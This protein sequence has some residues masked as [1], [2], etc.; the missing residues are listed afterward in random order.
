MPL[1]V[2]QYASAVVRSGLVTADEMKALWAALPAGQ[3]PKDGD[4][5][6]KVLV[7]A[8]KLTEFQ[9]GELASGSDT[10]LALGDYL[11]LARIGAGGMGQVFKAEHRHMR[12]L[13]AI[14]LLPATLT[15]DEAA[16][17]RFQREVQAAARLSHTNIVQTFDAG[18]QRGVWYL[19]MEYVEGRDL[20]AL[21]KANGPLTVHDAVN[22]TLQAARGL[23]FAHGDGVVHRDIKPANLLLDSKG[24]VKIL[25][26]GLARIDEGDSADHQLTNTGQVMGTVD[27]MAPEQATNTHSA[28]ARSDVYSLGCTLFRLLT[29]GNVYEGTTVVEKILAHI[30]HPVPSLCERSP[31]VPEEIDRI[32][33][34]MVAKKPEDRHQTAAE[35]VKDLEAWLRGS[36]G[37]ESSFATEDSK[38]H[39]FIQSVKTPGKS[40]V[41]SSSSTKAGVATATVAAKPTT[42][43]QPDVTISAQSLDVDTDPHSQRFVT[44][45]PVASPKPMG[46]GASKIPMPVI[47]AG[48]AAGFL[49]LMLGI[50]M[51]VRDRGGQE[52][53]RVK[54][55]DGGTATV[56]TTEPTGRGTSLPSLDSIKTPPTPKPSPPSIPTQPAGPKPPSVAKPTTSSGEDVPATARWPLA[57]SKPEDIAWL[58]TIP[59]SVVN[60]R[61]P[62]KAWM[63]SPQGAPPT[64]PATVVGVEFRQ[65]SGPNITDETLKRV[66]TLTDLEWLKLGFAASDSRMTK[67]GLWHLTKLPHLQTLVLYRAGPPDTDPA[68][69]A[70]FP[71]LESL[72]FSF[73][74]TYHWEEGVT[75]SATIREITMYRIPLPADWAPFAR[76]PRLECVR[77]FKSSKEEFR[78]RAQAVQAVAP[79]VRVEVV[80]ANDSQ[81]NDPAWI[82]DFVTEPT[83]PRPGSHSASAPVAT[84]S[85]PVVTAAGT[86]VPPPAV[87]PFDA[88]QAKAHQEAWAKYLGEPVETTNS[89]G[90][91]LTIIPPG[92]FK[93]GQDDSYT[94]TG[95]VPVTLTQPFRLGSHEVTQ[96]QWKAVMGTEPWKF[97]TKIDEGNSYPASRIPWD[98]AI[99]FCQKLTEKERAAGLIQSDRAYRLPTEA[100]WEIACRA[101]TATPR[102]FVVSGADLAEFDDY[103]WVRAPVGTHPHEVGLKK[104]NPWGLYDIY[105]N[106]AEWCQ[107]WGEGPLTGGTDPVGPT[108][109]TKRCVRGNM[110]DSKPLHVTSDFRYSLD[111]IAAHVHRNVGF[112]VALSRT[113]S[114]VSTQARVPAAVRTSTSPAVPNP[115]IVPSPSGRY[116]IEFAGARVTSPAPFVSEVIIDNLNLDDERPVT[117]ELAMTWEEGSDRQSIYLGHPGGT[118]IGTTSRNHPMMKRRSIAID[119]IGFETNKHVHLALVYGDG[120]LRGFRDGKLVKM[121]EVNPADPVPQRKP[122]VLGKGLKGRITMARISS[123]ARYTADYKPTLDF[124]PDQHTIALYRFDKDTGDVLEDL[125]GNNHHGKIIGATWVPVDAPSLS[126]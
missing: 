65:G 109:G 83:A 47:V 13:A 5:L 72:S 125:S 62:K 25:D 69:L 77:F 122:F 99:D 40:G 67:A 78:K 26:M 111:P 45:S 8:G 17:R 66:A 49:F 28:D 87:A 93:V 12:R 32:F 115:P 21:V 94:R 38:L 107:D 96:G 121:V 117:L 95:S 37:D 91:K 98:A 15:K 74:P 27:Y 102:F 88:A 85:K 39:D 19:V 116:A 56:E 61:S 123:V 43:A 68:V 18:V 97:D 36:G 84:P 11:L 73:S 30:G 70:A 114:G 51:I 50:W 106:V 29:A 16:V 124:T 120:K 20:S 54:I 103:A 48:G 101:G 63:L 41:L 10:P 112:R 100:E 14:K 35:V 75:R 6:A 4:G 33:Q 23:A 76:M 118:C 126:P 86:H 82:R 81:R 119:A 2:D 46:G 59:D 52:V 105:G 89:I 79:W 80:P 108:T 55:P 92:D 57:P 113:G 22:Y 110:V 9:A 24:T 90:M 44:G 34:K 7:E 60:L 53:A 42:T 1:T 58:Q 71:A 3:R 104:P 64:D 31:D